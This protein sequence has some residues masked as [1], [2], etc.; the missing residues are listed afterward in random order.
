MALTV[1]MMDSARISYRASIK[2]GNRPKSI[3]HHFLPYS[4]YMTHMHI[5]EAIT[6]VRTCPS[7]AGSKAL[8]TMSESWFNICKNV[9][10]SINQHRQDV[11]QWLSW[12]LHAWTLAPHVHFHKQVYNESQFESYSA[13][14]IAEACN[15]L[16]GEWSFSWSKYCLLMWQ[17]SLDHTKSAI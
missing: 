10:Y 15:G 12:H 3:D 13:A 7:R 17:P 1:S 8:N 11:A 14:C 16:N 2:S 9:V 4:Y 6:V 5:C